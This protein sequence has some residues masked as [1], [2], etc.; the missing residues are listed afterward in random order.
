MFAGAGAGASPL[1]RTMDV[2]DGVDAPAVWG[3]TRPVKASPMSATSAVRTHRR[4]R[5]EASGP[6]LLTRPAS[7]SKMSLHGANIS[8][9]GWCGVQRYIRL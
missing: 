1:G 3:A 6:Y 9:K 8:M 5:D 2:D 7:I 4:G